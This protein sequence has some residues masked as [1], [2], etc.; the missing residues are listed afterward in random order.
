MACVIDDS[1]GVNPSA[2][3]IEHMFP[4][5]IIY[6][7]QLVTPLSKCGCIVGIGICLQCFFHAVGTFADAVAAVERQDSSLLIDDP[8]LAPRDLGDG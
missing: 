5:R 1:E 2:I 7:E 6:W 8:V 4:F 3:E